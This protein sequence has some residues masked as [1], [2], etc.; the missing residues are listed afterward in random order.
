MGK[1]LAE[2]HAVFDNLISVSKN[3]VHGN[4]KLI[5][6][7][8]IIEMWCG[9]FF[10]ILELMVALPDR[11]AILAGRMPHFRAEISAAT[12]TNKSCRKNALAVVAPADAFSAQKF[13]LN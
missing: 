10:T 11:P 6:D 9:T 5:L 2:Y 1:I 8:F 13:S 3:S 4:Q 12:F 7:M